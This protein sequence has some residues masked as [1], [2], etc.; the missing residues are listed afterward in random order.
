MRD[1]LP[2][3]EYVSAEACTM[4]G[5]TNWIIEQ[6]NRQGR[7]VS[8][9]CVCGRSHQSFGSPRSYQAFLNGDER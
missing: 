3:V 2:V 1:A 7:P 9:S 4:C 6:R 8:V 5:G